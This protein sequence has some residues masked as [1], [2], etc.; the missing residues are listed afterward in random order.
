MLFQSLM[1]MTGTVAWISLMSKLSAVSGNSV[2]VNSCGQHCCSRMMLLGCHASLDRFIACLRA[3][4]SALFSW[5]LL[6]SSLLSSSFSSF[7]LPLIPV[8]MVLA[9]AT[10]VYQHCLVKQQSVQQGLG[11]VFIWSPVFNTCQM[12]A[13]FASVE[14]NQCGSMSPQFSRI[15]QDFSGENANSSPLQACSW[16]YLWWLQN[17]VC[18]QFR[19]KVVISSIQMFGGKGWLCCRI[20]VS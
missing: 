18:I 11:F 14:K 19:W 12:L 2:K 6:F 20:T 8:G 10:I 4:P 17:L 7:S 3:Q 1:G 16:P 13:M 9:N 15:L 5:L